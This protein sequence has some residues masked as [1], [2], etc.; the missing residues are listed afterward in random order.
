MAAANEA[1]TRRIAEQL[2][3]AFDGPTWTG[4][5]VADIVR[6]TS[7][8]HAARAPGVGVNSVWQL[9]LHIGCWVE[10]T[11]IRLSGRAHAPTAAENMPMVTDRSEAAWRAAWAGVEASYRALAAEIE[12]FPADRLGA[13]VAGKDYDNYHML[14]GVIQHTLYHAGQMALLTRGN[15]AT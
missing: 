15:A 4:V 5:T 10:V 2:R 14:H 12:R 13:P 8:E 6:R 7:A 9:L 11:R 1:E 3:W